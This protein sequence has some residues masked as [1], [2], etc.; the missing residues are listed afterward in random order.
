MTRYSLAL[1]LFLGICLHE[2]T[3]A[4]NQA[5]PLPMAP[6]VINQNT[7]WPIQG[8]PYP[9]SVYPVISPYQTQ[10][11][12]GEAFPS[13]NV[14]SPTFSSF[15]TSTTGGYNPVP[16]SGTVLQQ[17]YPQPAKPLVTP[18]GQQSPPPLSG[19]PLLLR[20]APLQEVEPPAV[21]TPGLATIKNGQWVTSDFFY[22]LPENIGLKVEFL[23]PQNKVLPI[24]EASIEQNIR[25]ILE[26]ASI[27][28]ETQHI[29][30]E[31][32]LPI[33]HVIVM[34]YPCGT[35]CVG[36]VTA[37]LYERGQPQRIDVDINGIWQL[38]TWERQ[39][40]VASSC[41]DFGSEINDTIAGMTQAFADSFRH[42]HPQDMVPCFDVEEGGTLPP[43]QP[44][45]CNPR[46]PYRS[47]FSSYYTQ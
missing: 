35:R 10:G 47:P 31:P 7:P 4:Q 5:L 29:P 17:V 19:M 24:N 34:A 9:N 13:F 18:P 16:S 15:N 6:T 40:M 14:P 2:L 41:D 27:I 22:N 38:V 32:P 28:T 3:H 11:A 37:Q 33:Y 36:F 39:A 1:T 23:K 46:T 20:E 43:P 21:L 25:E 45:R 8:D 30:C 26:Q 12:P 44:R 42:Y